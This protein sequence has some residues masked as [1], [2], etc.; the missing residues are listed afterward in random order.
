MPA[1]LERRDVL[2][3]SDDDACELAESEGLRLPWSLAAPP[4]ADLNEDM[5]TDGAAEGPR[6][7]GGAICGA[8]Q[9]ERFVYR[10]CSMDLLSDA[11]CDVVGAMSHGLSSAEASLQA[12]GERLVGALYGRDRAGTSER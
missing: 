4:A 7:P 11:E 6:G 9:L 10:R 2:R 5:P 1:V 12:N 8:L 3:R